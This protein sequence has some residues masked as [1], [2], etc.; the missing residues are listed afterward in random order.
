M[1]ILWSTGV[2]LLSLAGTSWAFSLKVNRVGSPSLH[3]IKVMMAHKN[4]MNDE[5]KLKNRNSSLKNSSLFFQIDTEESHRMKISKLRLRKVVRKVLISAALSTSL[6]FKGT[7]QISHAVTEET[8]S[9]EEI[10]LLASEEALLAE[11]SETETSVE[12]PKNVKTLVIAAGTAMIAMKVGS[13]FMG[14]GDDEDDRVQVI[15]NSFTNTGS[16]KG[17]DDEDE[18]RLR[19]L[20][21][22]KIA[23]EKKLAGKVRNL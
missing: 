14:K 3:D 16:G 20:E 2:I 23:A 11:E 1:L 7:S 19:A 4:Q 17:D 8:I 6:W 22:R 9:T 5:T 15:E 18:E 12:K 13:S 21:E 10:K